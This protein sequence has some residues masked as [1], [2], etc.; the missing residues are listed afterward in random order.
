MSPRGP[1]SLT[2]NSGDNI[3]SLRDS[4]GRERIER[5]F[6]DI[7]VA[8]GQR[9]AAI[10]AKMLV[11]LQS[12]F[13]A[14]AAP[15][16]A[17]LLSNPL[18]WD[19]EDQN[20][21][22]R[23][24]D[25]YRKLS[26]VGG[27]LAASCARENEGDAELVAKVIAL[28]LLHAGNARKWEQIATQMGRGGYSSLHL[29]YSTARKLDM[30]RTPQRIEVNSLD[31]EITIEALYVRAMLL[32]RLCIGSLNRQ[33]IEI[34]DNWL[35]AWMPVLGLTSHMPARGAALCADL[36]GDLGFGLTLS[37][38]VDSSIY[39]PL[40]ALQRQLRRAVQCFH[41]G[42][43][44]PGW[45]FATEFRLEEHIGVIEYLRSEFALIEQG[46]RAERN[47]RIYANDS[48]VEIFVGLS[49]ILTRGFPD[50]SVWT[51]QTDSRIGLIQRAASAPARTQSDQFS[52]I[53]DPMRRQM[54]LKDYNESGLGLLATRDEAATVS[55]GD[56][57]AVRL[58]P[59][60]PC[61][62]GEVVRKAPCTSPTDTLIGIS[63]ISRSAQRVLLEFR[64]KRDGRSQSIA[65]LFV[66]GEDAFGTSDGFIVSHATDQSKPEANVVDKGDK[67]TFVLNRLR[68]KGRGW[69]LSGFD[70]S[71]EPVQEVVEPEGSVK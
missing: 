47:E 26:D 39:L 40:A 8:Q 45:G 65:A 12:D 11:P 71:K 70:S 15:E 57:I 49:D 31:M 38:E 1:D 44:F 32:K 61:V 42:E 63:I 55:A 5:A 56:L 25:W 29:L 23:I 68:R 37:H 10:A 36:R 3:V 43:I 2:L 67:F 14:L 41:R 35:C 16:Q 18:L 7:Q 24:F 19:Q 52:L 17:R 27:E 53:Y 21:S 28:A 62:L 60:Q 22:E 51:R 66:P 54:R 13:A 34:L 6:R 69:W 64:N 48:V 46:I 50:L 9:S 58:E 30:H 59:G 33:Q 4:Q 20:L